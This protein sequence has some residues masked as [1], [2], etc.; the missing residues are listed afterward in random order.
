MVTQQSDTGSPARSAGGWIQPDDVEQTVVMT[1]SRRRSRG[2]NL[3]VIPDQPSWEQSIV[4][5]CQG[6]EIS[7]GGLLANSDASLTEE[8]GDYYDAQ[9]QQTRFA[10]SFTFA[11]VSPTPPVGMSVEY[12]SPSGVSV[13][14]AVISGTYTTNITNSLGEFD[15]TGFGLYHAPVDDAWYSPADVAGLVAGGIWT[16]GVYNEAGA[17]TRPVSAFS[18]PGAETV[19]VLAQAQAVQTMHLSTWGVGGCVYRIT[20]SATQTYRPPRYRFV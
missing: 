2:T 1:R 16:A 9:A 4:E 15:N 5:A 6:T 11:A 14:D 12:E 7:T 19:F 18:V 10:A 13:S 20:L 17:V 3:G 8:P